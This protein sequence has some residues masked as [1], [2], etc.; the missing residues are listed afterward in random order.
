MNISSALHRL[1]EPAARAAVTLINHIGPVR[2]LASR[3]MINHFSYLA[4]ARPR[5]VSMAAD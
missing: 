5:A 1:P 4:P 3:V 2:R